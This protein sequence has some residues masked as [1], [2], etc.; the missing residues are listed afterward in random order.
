M[1]KHCTALGFR[2]PGGG[3]VNIDRSC[4]F[5]YS[6]L[7]RS[8]RK[9]LRRWEL[10]FWAWRRVE[11]ARSSQSLLYP[12][13]AILSTSRGNST[14]RGAADI[15]FFLD[16]RHQKLNPS[17]YETVIEMGVGVSLFATGLGAV[18][19]PSLL[20]SRAAAATQPG[21]PFSAPRRRL[22]K[23]DDPGPSDESQAARVT[24]TNQADGSLSP[25]KEQ[26]RVHG[27]QP[28]NS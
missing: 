18:K 23:I 8:S 12:R 16:P 9:I 24:V 6:L 20:E 5:H 7:Y 11:E 2:I 26:F 17:I 3:D 25:R 10:V 19:R 21:Q 15:F 13:N 1:R 27:E 22:T 14:E 4:M 28:P